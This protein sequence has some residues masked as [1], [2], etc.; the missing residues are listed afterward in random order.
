[1]NA[2]TRRFQAGTIT[3]ISAGLLATVSWSA[4]NVVIKHKIGSELHPAV[5]SFGLFFSALTT[6]TP[7]SF[8][9]WKTHTRDR[10]AFR[11]PRPPIVACAARTGASL[12]F[13]YATRTIS[14][15]QT[16]M[17]TRLNPIWVCAIL[18]FIDRD[19]IKRSSLLG[20]A[21]SFLGIYVIL[22][23]WDKAL[24]LSTKVVWGSMAALLCGLCQAIFA[25]SL[26][27]GA[28]KAPSAGLAHKIQ[29]TTALIGVCLLMTLPFAILFFPADMPDPGGVIWIWI[30]GAIFNACAYVLYYWCLTLVP[31]I[32]AVVILSLTLPFTMLI[33][34]AF[35]GIETPPSLVVGALL[36]VCGILYVAKS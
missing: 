1:M 36:V 19:R 30:G 10:P 35:Y 25:V 31:E 18:F 23:G 7:F 6:L 22:G 34:K 14:A 5:V 33:E 16:T 20:G 26:K 9:L 2:H 8:V 21:L 12:L 32:L 29:F 13:V 3:G 17:Y 28:S 27:R 11:L 15:T 4:M 24:S